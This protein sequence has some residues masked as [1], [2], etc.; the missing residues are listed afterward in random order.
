MGSGQG[1][2]HVI[3]CT[4]F[5]LVL[6]LTVHGWRDEVGHLDAVFQVVLWKCGE[7]AVIR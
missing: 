3:L 5:V 6:L 2:T 4:L 7:S 1:D